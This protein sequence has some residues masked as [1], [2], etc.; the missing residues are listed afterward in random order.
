[1]KYLSAGFFSLF[2]GA[3]YW[4]PL[5]FLATA[6][7]QK[8]VETQVIAHRGA[9]KSQDLPENSIAALNH[10]IALGCYGAEFDVHMTK[11]SIPVVNHDADFKG[12]DIEKTNYAEL[13][14]VP[15]SNGE[16]IPTL[17]AYLK[18]GLKQKQCRLILEIKKAPS[19]KERTLLLTRLAVDMVKELGGEQQ[20]EYISFDFDAGSLVGQLSPDSQVAYL[21]GDKTPLEAKKAGYT[22]IDYNMKVYREHPQ[23]IQEAQQQGLSVNVWTVNSQEDLKEF[24]QNGVDFITTNEPERL[25]DILE[26]GV[27]Y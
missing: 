10:A 17:E 5:F 12:M 27:G 21:N 15:L 9:W 23:W 24:I 26:A 13:L 6:C 20:V 4:L 11:D 25:F 8:N 14:A 1:M 22:G 2:R 18:E 7:T 3:C 19:G 16:K